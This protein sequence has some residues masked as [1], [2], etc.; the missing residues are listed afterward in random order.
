ML[1]WLLPLK[2]AREKKNDKK[3]EAKLK[4]R[5]VSKAIS[6]PREG[7]RVKSLLISSQSECFN[8]HRAT[9]LE[10]AIL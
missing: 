7:F 8:F 3:S 1:T 9:Q 6:K 4:P 10:Y 2:I 5:A